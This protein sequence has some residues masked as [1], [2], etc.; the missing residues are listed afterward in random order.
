MRLFV[1]LS[2]I[3]FDLPR[4][5]FPECLS[6]LLSFS[7]DTILFWF[8]RGPLIFKFVFS[9]IITVGDHFIVGLRLLIKCCFRVSFCAHSAGKLELPSAHW[10]PAWASAGCAALRGLSEAGA[11]LATSRPAPALRLR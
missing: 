6:L 5:I 2:V 3:C 10:A 7:V 11:H 8:N 4:A 1:E 9:F